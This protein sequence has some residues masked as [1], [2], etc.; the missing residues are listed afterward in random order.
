MQVETQEKHHGRRSQAMQGS[1]SLYPST[2]NRRGG[3]RRSGKM[4]NPTTLWEWYLEWC[5]NPSPLRNGFI[6]TIR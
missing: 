1:A 3:D 5:D 4:M 2:A 6:P